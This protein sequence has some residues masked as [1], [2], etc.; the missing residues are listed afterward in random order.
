MSARDILI[1]P[2]TP[3]AFA[4]FGTVIDKAAVAPRPMNAGKARRY[5]D[6]AEVPVAGEGSRVVI[7]HVEA[8]PYA[9]PLSLS[10]VERHPL[11]AQAFVPL[12]PAPF[13]VV[14]CPDEDGRPGRPRAFLTAPG[15]GVCYGLNVWHGVLTPLNAP[16]DFLVIDRGGP[17]SNLEEHVFEEP[18]TI[19]PPNAA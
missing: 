9:L 5:H 6:L 2:L 1:A 14:V 11:G 13:L 8:E 4:P 16:Q 15:H 7:G 19:L 17:G 12:S 10:L 3:E 18:W